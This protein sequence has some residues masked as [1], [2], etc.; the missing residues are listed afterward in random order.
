[1]IMNANECKEITEEI[2]NE[3]FK[4]SPLARP[5]FNGVQRNIGFIQTPV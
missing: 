3:L 5:G 1:M 2:F 4:N